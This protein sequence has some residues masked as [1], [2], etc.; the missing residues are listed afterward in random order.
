MAGQSPEELLRSGLDILEIPYSDNQISSFLAYL[1]ELKKWNRAYNLTALKTDGD[2]IVKHFLDSLLFL[3][4]LP[5]HVRTAAD[6]GSGAGFPGIPLKIMCPE[7]SFYLIEPTQKKALFLKHVCSRLGLRGVAILNSRIE[8]V[9]GLKV[10]AAMTRALFSVGEFIE[11]TR[12]MLNEKG[13]LILSKGPKIEVELKGLETA[14]V[15]ITD[16]ELPFEKIVRHMIT[17]NG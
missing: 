7:I 15:Q 10:D 9:G 11:K 2:I 13:V 8:D 16:V 12:G 6:I 3:K 5:E 17:V 14:K 4:V 1:S